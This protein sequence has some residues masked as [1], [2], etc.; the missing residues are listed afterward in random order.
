[1]GFRTQADG[2]GSK[3]MIQEFVDGSRLLQR[4]GEQLLR[5]VEQLAGQQQAEIAPLRGDVLLIL[6]ALPLLR[7]RPTAI[8]SRSLVQSTWTSAET[9]PAEARRRGPANGRRMETRTSHTP[10]PLESL[11]GAMDMDDSGGDPAASPA[12]GTSSAANR[13]PAVDPTPDYESEDYLQEVLRP[14]A[15]PARSGHRGIPERGGQCVGEL[16]ATSGRI[17]DRQVQANRL[18]HRGI[19]EGH[20]QEQAAKQL[21]LSRN[22]VK[23]IIELVQDAYTRFAADANRAGASP[24]MRSNSMSRDTTPPKFAAFAAGWRGSRTSRSPTSLPRVTRNC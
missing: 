14:P 4:Q 12:Y 10:H 6:E 15:R 3:L 22:Q 9:G 8:Y 20:T 11:D 13:E 24:N 21:G 2:A 18:G 16:G 23:Y 5:G 1:M 7:V 17:V 19:G